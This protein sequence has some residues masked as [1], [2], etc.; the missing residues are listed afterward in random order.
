[1]VL[2]ASGP[3]TGLAGGHTET[4]FMSVPCAL[5]YPRCQIHSSTHC[6]LEKREKIPP[7][8][9]K[10]KIKKHQLLEDMSPQ[11]VSRPCAALSHMLFSISSDNWCEGLS[12]KSEAFTLCDRLPFTTLVRREKKK[13][14]V[15]PNNCSLRGYANV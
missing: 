15:V 11:R 7:F 1:M 4:R 13:T 12:S 6:L 9:F 2:K 14:P 8:F 3:L 10:K 5:L